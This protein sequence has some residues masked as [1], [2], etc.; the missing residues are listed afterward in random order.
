MK[1]L[2]AA[3]TAALALLSFGAQTQAQTRCATVEVEN[4]RPGQGPLMLAAYSDAASFG[5][6]ASALLREEATA[7]TMQVQVC[8]L[9]GNV[10]ALTLY[11]DLDRNGVLDTNAFGVPLE[12]WG[13]SGNPPADAAPT[14]ATTAVPLDGAP[15]FVK[16]SG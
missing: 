1:H 10:V 14:W 12:P 7:A 9:P 8:G 16:L 5:V 2:L 13:A 3:C 15:L 4:L 6:S 11:Q